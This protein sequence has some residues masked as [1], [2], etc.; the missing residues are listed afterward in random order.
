MSMTWRNTQSGVTFIELII[1]IILIGIALA[2]VFS[3]YTYV[4]GRSAD[5]MI[6]QQAVATAESYLEEILLR[7]FND[8]DTGAPCSEQEA[9]RD[10][11]DDVC[12]YDGLSGQPADQFGTP[13]GLPAYT[14]TVSVDNTTNDLGLGAGNEMRIDVTVAHTNGTSM[15]ITGYRTN[16]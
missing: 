10:L 4:I 14:V 15:Q 8:P 11:Y 3:V 1:T 12:D 5:P 2:G 16:Y 9:S 13:L 7:P 6:Q